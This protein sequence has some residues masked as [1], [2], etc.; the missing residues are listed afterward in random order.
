MADADQMTPAAWLEYL[1]AKLYNRAK[2]IQTFMDYRDGNHRLRFATQKYR[3]T[4]AGLFGTFC[5]NWCNPVVEVAVERLRVEGFRF[6]EDQ[7]AAD[8]AWGIWQANNLDAGSTMAHRE[9]ITCGEVYTLVTPPAEEGGMPKITIEHPLQMIVECSESDPNVRVAALKKWLSRD[10]YLRAT[11][12]LPNVIHRFRSQEKRESGSP[13][14]WVRLSEA[15]SVPNLMGVVPVI[16]LRNNP[17]L[18]GGGRSD[19]EP[20]VP[21]N[22]AINKLA[23]DMV[24]ASEFAAFPQRIVTGIEVPID[25]V[26]NR[27]T[28]AG[29]ETGVSRLMTLANPEAKWGTFPAADLKNYVAGIDMLLQHLAAQTRTP[30]HYLIG[31]VVNASGD[32]L[33]A[34]ETGLTEKSRE[35][36]VTFGDGWE[37]T[38]RVAFKSRRTSKDLERSE[39]S[40]AET[41][42]RDPENKSTGE[43]VDA[44]VKKRQVLSVPLETLWADVGYTPQQIEEFKRLLGLPERPAPGALAGTVPALNGGTNGATGA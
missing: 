21:L 16:P 38:L 32:A 34:A 3:E 35:K 29:F 10:G 28:S 44:A 22:D 25:P 9:A 13:L 1:D 17:T 18:L 26:T 43:L 42:W 39:I 27:P 31:Q 41:R 15:G 40:D 30:P 6:G 24:I 7:E 33:K 5:D 23:L 14:Q 11:L 4:F 8:Q 36:T 12:Y 20:A 2:V 19:L 37:E